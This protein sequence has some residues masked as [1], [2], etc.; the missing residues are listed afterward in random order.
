[1][2]LTDDESVE[3]AFSEVKRYP[4]DYFFWNAGIWRK[5]PFVEHSLKDIDAITATNFTGP[6]K[7]LHRFHEAHILEKRPYRLIAISSVSAWRV[8][9]HE[10]VYCASKDA[11]AV[12]V[13]NFAGELAKELP[14]SQATVVYPGG[15][16]TEIFKGVNVDTTGYMDPRSVAKIVWDEIQ[17]QK[18]VCREV[19]LVRDK[20]K[21]DG[22]FFVEHG[23]KPRGIK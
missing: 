16:K 19:H 6:L 1:M 13:L 10:T 5:L 17:N 22:S 12:F 2:D 7:M 23:P 20:E 9:E 4:I 8:R 21:N 3:K 15:M 11:Q 14:G 18:E